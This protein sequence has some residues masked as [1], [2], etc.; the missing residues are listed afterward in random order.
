MVVQDFHIVSIST[1][2]I[3]ADAIL[4][5]DSKP[6]LTFSVAFQKLKS[7]SWWNFQIVELLRCMEHLELGYHPSLKVG[8]QSFQSPAV[9]EKLADI[10]ALAT[11]ITDL[12]INVKRYYRGV[13]GWLSAMVYWMGVRIASASDKR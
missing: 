3:E 4:I 13:L 2:T 8:R 7:I 11:S 9:L 12:V 10:L 5:V 6:V 1:S